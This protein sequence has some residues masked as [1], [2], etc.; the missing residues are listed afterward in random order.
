MSGRMMSM[1]RVFF[2]A[3]SFSLRPISTT[4]TGTIRRHPDLPHIKPVSELTALVPLQAEM[5]DHAWTLLAPGGRLVFCTCSLLPEEGETQIANAL[6]RLP[7]AEVDREALDR[8]G[9]E[10][11]WRS[12]EGGLRLRPDFWA[13]TG[14]MD[15]FYMACLR[16]P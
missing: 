7:G 4:A 9:I 2:C 12:S 10:P 11:S 15:G 14:G 5:L 6:T 13:E 16:K 8:P 1:R 3:A